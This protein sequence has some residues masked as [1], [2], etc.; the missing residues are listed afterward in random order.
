MTED[1]V[2]GICINGAQP[3]LK[4][5]LSMAKPENIAALLKLPV[6]VSEVITDEP[7]QQMFQVL[8][9]K[10]DNLVK[11]ENRE[12]RQV[13]FQDQQRS[14][15]RSPA[16]YGQRDASLMARQTWQRT[17]PAPLR[18]P[19]WPSDS[20]DMGHRHDKSGLSHHGNQCLNRITDTRTTR[21]DNKHHSN[22]TVSVGGDA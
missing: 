7:I 4:A 8:N 9:D 10:F 18:R 17:T 5:H 15:S 11:R 20:R 21:Y 12:A 16:R 22:A 2:K 1:E 14:T 13:T 6:V 19:T 3:Q